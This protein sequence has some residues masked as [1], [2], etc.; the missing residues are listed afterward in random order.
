TTQQLRKL[1]MQLGIRQC[2]W[3]MWTWRWIT[4]LHNSCEESGMK[5]DCSR[6]GI[7]DL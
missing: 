2:R 7:P 5:N 6:I 3:R 1:G 4:A